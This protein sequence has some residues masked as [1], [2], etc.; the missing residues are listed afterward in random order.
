M[1]ATDEIA[2]SAAI[3]SERLAVFQAEL[4][5]LHAHFCPRQVLGLRMGILAGELLGLAL[6]RSDKRLFVFV[7]TDGCLAD[8]ISVSTGAWLGHRTLRLI[9]HGKTA[10]TFVD[11]TSRHAIRIWPQGEARSRAR[12]YAPDAKDR[13]HAQRDG[14]LVMPVTEL[15]VAERVELNLDLTTLISQ[16]G[17]RRACTRCGEDIVN[18]REIVVDG[19]V[20]CRAC[21]GEAYFRPLRH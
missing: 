9:D 19:S 18:E 2:A 15:L 8:A 12:L 7:E 20:R 17:R 5:R 3:S 1:T 13:W 11:T 6:P 10:A 21:A 16:P 4:A 14:Y